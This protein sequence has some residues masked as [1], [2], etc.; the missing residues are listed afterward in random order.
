MAEVARYC[1]TSNNSQWEESV[2]DLFNAM[3]VAFDKLT[4]D[5]GCL[6]LENENQYADFMTNIHRLEMTPGFSK[7]V[8]VPEWKT[9][10]N[11]GPY[12]TEEN[13]IQSNQTV[14][15]KYTDQVTPINKVGEQAL[16]SYDIFS[17]S[18]VYK[19]NFKVDFRRLTG[20]DIDSVDL[21][22]LKP[23]IPQP[24]PDKAVYGYVVVDGNNVQL[25]DYITPGT[26]VADD[27]H[28][29]PGILKKDITLNSK[30]PVPGFKV[31]FV[32]GA[33]WA[34][35]WGTNGKILMNFDDFETQSVSSE[36]S[37]LSDVSEVSAIDYEEEFL[38]EDESEEEE[39]E[40][41]PPPR[42]G[43]KKDIG[44]G[45]L[46]R[47]P[48]TPTEDI[49]LD[50]L[51]FAH[52]NG[53]ESKFLPLSYVLTQAAQWRIIYNA[54]VSNFVDIGK[55]PKVSDYVLGTVVDSILYS[56]SKRISPSRASLALLKYAEKRGV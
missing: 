38:S 42:Y 2:I 20:V 23:R 14:K 43:T 53:A 5:E 12:V 21:T 17:D 41:V 32:P 36:S 6:T 15:N 37:L 3:D 40:Y 16:Y 9:I 34:A 27:G 51:D 35:R 48:F 56:V 25:S 7:P 11:K 52:L 29:I 47:V 50:T 13:Y 10:V 1:F 49:E 24:I 31:A 28:I 19:T 54:F 45:P 39:E 22:A 30:V 4:Q 46:S 55:L 18:Q 26:Y 44:Y 8:Y 33:S